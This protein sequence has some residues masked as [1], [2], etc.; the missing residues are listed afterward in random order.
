VDLES[1]EGIVRELRLSRIW[2]DSLYDK[3][4]QQGLGDYV[5]ELISDEVW[6]LESRRDA[7][8][9]RGSGNG[10]RLTADAPG[11]RAR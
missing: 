7:V 9:D 10:P 6:D 4:E 5:C 11:R 8:R 1:V 2:S 3:L